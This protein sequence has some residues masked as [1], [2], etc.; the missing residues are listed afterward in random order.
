MTAYRQRNST[1]RTRDTAGQGNTGKG[2]L[3]KLAPVVLVLAGVTAYSNSFDK[4]FVYDDLE[5]I[6][7]NRHVEKLC[8]VR[9]AMTAP[10]DT[11]P[12]GRPL[13]A[14]SLAVNYAVSGREVW[15]YHV[16]NM[17][18]HLLAGLTLF[19]VVRRTMLSERLR[20]RFGQ[21]AAPIATAVALL[22]L[23]HPLQTEAVTYVIQRA[24]SM[25]ALLYLLTLYCAI[26]GHTSKRK[27]IWCVASVIA[28]AA[29]MASKEVM[30]TAPLMV[31]AYDSI[32][33]SGSLRA[34]I[35]KRRF[36]YLSLAGTWLLLALLAA[37]GG[38]S[39]SAGF[40]FKAVSP[41]SYAKTQFAVILHYIRLTSWPRPLV[42]DYGW[43]VAQSLSDWLGYALVVSVM[44]AGTLAALV[45]RPAA[46]FAALWFFAVLAPTSSFMPIADPICEHRMY[47]PLA[48][49]VCGAVVCAY[50]L[51]A[52]LSLRPRILASMRATVVIAVASVL[53]LAT[54][55]RNRDYS[56]ELTIW[57]ETCRNRPANKRA[58]SL[59][60][61]AYG[62]AGKLDQALKCYDRS[63]EIDDRYGKAYLGR[64][65]V[66]ARNGLYD[67]AV[68][69]L[70]NAVTLMPGYYLAHANL[71]VAHLHM[72]D[73]VRAVKG[74]RRA[75]ELNPS[76]PWVQDSLA[77]A[78]RRLERVQP[79]SATTRSTG[80][81]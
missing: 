29:G 17:L 55:S 69:D 19:G 34:A 59:L 71:A 20:S 5:A 35:S 2:L 77:E 32:F 50:S 6:V 74:F 72:G 22:W 27:R 47:L 1:C 26:R 21:V 4:A 81:G 67:K 46:G 7:Y 70:T 42:L 24:E 30:V 37:G 48:G 9:Q 43:P 68:T 79:Q 33:Q 18:V 58:W 64:G 62:S 76:D 66:L 11:T 53:A 25:M 39:T 15:S 3:E 65:I 73:N 57:K 56:S 54:F 49:V 45:R 38:R 61:M 75:L 63:L 10:P 80:S 51:S 40:A 31:L 78:R 12:S 8:P 14:L 36:F 41:I 44:L 23:V 28:C 52:R 13:V 16:F 60:G